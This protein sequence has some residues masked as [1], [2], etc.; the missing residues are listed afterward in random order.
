M[1]EE[2]INGKVKPISMDSA[3]AKFVKFNRDMVTDYNT[4]CSYINSL[5][6][7]REAVGGDSLT[8]HGYTTHK[9]VYAEVSGYTPETL[10]EVV[11]SYEAAGFSTVQFGID[12]DSESN[13]H[14]LGV[15]WDE[16]IK[17]STTELDTLIKFFEDEAEG[18][19]ALADTAETM[20]GIAEVDSTEKPDLME[21]MVAGT[22]EEF[23]ARRAAEGDIHPEPAMR[24]DFETDDME[25]VVTG[26][27]P[28]EVA[29]PDIPGDDFDPDM[30]SGVPDFGSMTAEIP[31][32]SDEA[33]LG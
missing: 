10:A 31:T 8:V 26:F 20:D 6:F 2:I 7:G 14:F 15:M 24:S 19:D 11:K 29:V 28:A 33:Y 16:N 4:L 25:P 22:T 3:N 30:P 23:L 5:I 13:I 12:A 17:V 18:D 9:V 27:K 1:S 21:H 32:R